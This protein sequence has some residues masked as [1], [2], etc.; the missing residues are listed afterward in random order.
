MPRLRIFIDEQERLGADIGG[1][2]PLHEVVEE[3]ARSL[4]AVFDGKSKPMRFN[5]SPNTERPVICT[6]CGVEIPMH[7]TYTYTIDDDGED[8]PYHSKCHPIM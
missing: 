2:A 7:E 8:V 5:D 6:K 4:K 3:L 1:D